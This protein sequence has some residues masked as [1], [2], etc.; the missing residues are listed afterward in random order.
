MVETAAAAMNELSDH[1]ISKAKEL[2]EKGLNRWE[3]EDAL[4]IAPDYF[5]EIILDPLFREL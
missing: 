1:L 5:E 4:M 2:K 3:I